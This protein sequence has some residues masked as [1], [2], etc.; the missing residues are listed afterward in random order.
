MNSAQ[1]KSIVTLPITVTGIV[2]ALILW[3]TPFAI[4][5][6]L[7]LPFSIILIVLGFICISFGIILLW[8]TIHLFATRGNGTLAPWNP[9]S[10]LV[11]VGIYRYV[12]NPMISGV[13]FIVLGETLFFGSWPL[14]ILFGL[15]LALNLIYIPLS[16]EKSLIK[17]FGEDYLVYA[18][19][20]PRWIPRLKAWHPPNEE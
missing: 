8:I 14:L 17:R 5:W 10:K 1:I 6:N 19:N 9:P 7:L 18:R 20:V 4:G 11:V 12:R 13:L 16:E 2:P 15:F 3:L